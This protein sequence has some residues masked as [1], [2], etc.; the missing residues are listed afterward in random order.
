MV[1]S[2]VESR[3]MKAYTVCKAL[4]KNG[5]SHI[6]NLMK[7]T[8]L[9]PAETSFTHIHYYALKSSAIDYWLLAIG[10]SSSQKVAGHKS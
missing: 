6:D 8:E 4:N 5:H 10:Y 9:S 1:E 7:A 3:L 2:R